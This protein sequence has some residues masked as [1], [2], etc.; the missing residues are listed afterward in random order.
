MESY[1]KES[2]GET[3][4]NQYQIRKLLKKDRDLSSYS[5]VSFKIT[6][7]ENEFVML[8]D[9]KNWPSNSRIRE[10]ELD[11]NRSSGVKL[12]KYVNSGGS[13]ETGPTKNGNGSWTE[14]K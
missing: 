12:N 10:F 1:V 8:M 11:G 9:P 2:V 3:A 14:D 13:S 5:F 4:M 6:C 7:P